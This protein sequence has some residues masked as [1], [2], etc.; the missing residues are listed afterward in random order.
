MGVCRLL[1]RLVGSLWDVSVCFLWVCVGCLR[2]WSVACGRFRYVFCG[3]G[4]VAWGIASN[5]YS[6]AL[7][8][9][10][11]RYSILFSYI[12]YDTILYS[13]I[14]YRIVCGI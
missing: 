3:C 2:D 6:M 14:S 11:L 9:S 12:L 7:N 8:H 10:V 5:A 1:A 13:L 4:S